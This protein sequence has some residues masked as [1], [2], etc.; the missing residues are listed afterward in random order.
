MH[1]RT[2]LISGAALFGRGLLGALP[3][4]DAPT[5]ARARRGAM[6]LPPVQVSWDRILRT[7]VGLRPHRSSGFLLRAESFAGKTLIQNYG[8]GGAGMSLGWGCGELVADIARE[9]AHRRAA[10]IGCG[11]PGL[12][13][14]RQLQQRGFAVTIYA[15]TVPP[16]TTSNLSL[17]TFSPTAGLVSAGH[18]TA[19]WDTQF[20]RAAEISYREMLRLRGS[21]YGIGW[22]DSFTATED[23]A[24]P[25]PNADEAS[26]LPE[27]F[28]AQ[29][30]VLEPGEHPFPTTYALR[31]R[32]LKIEPRT[33][34]DALVSDVRQAGG[35]IVVR[36]FADLT[37]L[38]TLGEPVIVNCTGLGSRA[39]FGDE[40]LIPIK[41]QLT[42][43]KPQPEVRYRA[44]AG[45][46]GM[47]PRS[48][49]IVLGNSQVRGD[50]SLEP[51]EALRQ[52]V[53][54]AAGDFFGAMRA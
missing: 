2:L 35:R 42:V 12:T 28:Q 11:S 19:A 15:A 14:A 10:V 17:A 37:E 7:T 34:L 23:P 21:R 46:I 3:L 38:A 43:L 49:G 9:T 41:G 32:S 30:Q 51:D 25:E 20:R 6:A 40:E 24:P 47:M 16:D 54:T 44:T 27:Q 13:T 45:G 8:H 53:V 29:P 36:R 52:R 4:V 48:D 33:Y 5:A 18:R 1:R 22:I 26:L 31:T 39:L 50:W